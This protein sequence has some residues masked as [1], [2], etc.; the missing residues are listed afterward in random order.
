MRFLRAALGADRL[1]HA[2]IFGGP[3]GVGKGAVA[4]VLSRLLLCDAPEHAGSASAEPCGKC[5]ACRAVDAE[6]HPDFHHVY[7]QLI[8]LE[9]SQSR[10]RDLSIDVVRDHLIEPASRKSVLGRGK[11]FVVEEAHLMSA[12]AQNSLLKTLEEPAP[13]TLIV[14]LSD[15]PEQLLGT[16]RSRCQ[17]VLFRPLS[18]P[19]LLRALADRGCQPEP[20]QR[21]AELSGGSLGLSLRWIEDGVIDQHAA[22]L[23]V[24]RALP[25]VGAAEQLTELLKTAADKHAERQL[26]RDALTSKEQSTREGYALHLDLIQRLLAASMRG[27][28]G[29]AGLTATPSTLAGWIEAIDEALGLIDAN[30]T[31]QLMLRHLA[32]RLAMAE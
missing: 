25:D 6:T 27:A 28:S 12:S 20:A 3:V 5:A 31:G 17:A 4:G 26:E 10:A 16:I 9:K 1:P 2:M 18:R 32:D 7:R 22:L 19:A 14:L 8:R 29:S 13:R 24:L 15:H 23:P 30:V 21:A 11:A